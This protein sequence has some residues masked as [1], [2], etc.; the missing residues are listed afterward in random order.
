MLNYIHICII[1]YGEFVS[2]VF[3]KFVEFI[4]QK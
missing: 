2:T 4:S 3:N 1:H